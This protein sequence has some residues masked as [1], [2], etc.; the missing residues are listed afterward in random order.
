MRFPS[1]RQLL[2]ALA[3]VPVVPATAQFRRT[4]AATP[5]VDAQGDA[6][7][8][9]DVDV[10]NVLAT[11][12]DRRGAIVKTLQR[13][14]FLLFDDGAERD[15]VYFAQQTDTPLTIGILFDTSQS[16]RAVLEAQRE[17]AL[18]FLD[19]VLRPEQDQA[20]VIRFDADVELV[21][22]LTASRELLANAIR[23]LRSPDLGAPQRGPQPINFQVRIGI[24]GTRRRIP[25]PGGR[26]PQPPGGGTGRRVPSGAG[27]MLYDAVYLAAREVLEG[28]PGRKAILLISD[29]NDY[30]SKVSRDDAVEATQRA[31]AQI[32]SIL[33]YQETRVSAGRI[34][35]RGVNTLRHL[36]ANTGGSMY[37]VSEKKSI[38][39]VFLE[40]EEE[41]RNQYSLGFHPPPAAA[42]GFRPLELRVRDN[43]LRVQARQGYYVKPG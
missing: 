16:Q 1:R 32:C 20:F 3:G 11:V 33:Y 25:V 29:G 6:S 27:T 10:V 26:T 13:E 30:T 31:D 42:P 21:Q 14:D 19:R 15:I 22:D 8:R 40:V 38:D 28:Q 9:V 17:A 35:M 36:S 12:R 24:P 43:N 39:A 41:L 4:E 23:S 34:R 37:E 18:Q 2:A 7:F 5:R